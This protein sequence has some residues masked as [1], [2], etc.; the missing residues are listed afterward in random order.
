MPL[1]NEG[2]IDS[3]VDSPPGH[4]WPGRLALLTK[5]VAREKGTIA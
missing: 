4:G 5:P 2:E 1:K 3:V